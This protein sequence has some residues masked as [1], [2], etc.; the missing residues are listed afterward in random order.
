MKYLIIIGCLSMAVVITGLMMKAQAS[1]CYV[2]GS[3]ANALI[4]LAYCGSFSGHHATLKADYVAKNAFTASWFV[5]NS[6]THEHLCGGFIAP[7]QGQKF[8]LTCQLTPPEKFAIIISVGSVVDY[9]TVSLESDY[10]FLSPPALPGR[11]TIEPSSDLNGQSTNNT[12]Y[13]PYVPVK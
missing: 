13:F 12:L 8:S 1:S 7:Q 11:P 4:Q 10:L 2:G 3:P 9:P 6:L 5:E